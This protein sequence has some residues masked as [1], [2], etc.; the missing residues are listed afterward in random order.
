MFDIRPGEGCGVDWLGGADWSEGVADGILWP[1]AV[2]C[3][4]W[5][6]GVPIWP[7][8]VWA[9]NTPIANITMQKRAAALILFI[10]ILVSLVESRRCGLVFGCRLFEP[11]GQLI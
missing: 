3:G 8:F 2:V 1:G 4:D 5:V 10:L 9:N 6:D 11:R 7:E